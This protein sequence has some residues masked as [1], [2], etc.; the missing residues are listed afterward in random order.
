MEHLSE[1]MLSAII[2]GAVVTIL[3]QFKARLLA[4]VRSRKGADVYTL[5]VASGECEG[6]EYAVRGV[7]AMRECGKNDARL[8]I[9]AGE[10]TPEAR[11]RAEIIAHRAGEELYTKDSL[12]EILPL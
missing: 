8:V 5:I 6:L 2:V 9:V 1:I 11:E 4:P 10:L 7:E 3:I 12:W